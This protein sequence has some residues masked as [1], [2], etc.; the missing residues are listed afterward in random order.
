MEDLEAGLI[1]R[2]EAP[3]PTEKRECI[4]VYLGFVT[5]IGL[6][7]FVTLFV[8]FMIPLIN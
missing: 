8:F 2:G 6:I 5:I 1:E 4:R 3:E 7:L